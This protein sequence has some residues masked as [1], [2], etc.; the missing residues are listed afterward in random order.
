MINLDAVSGEIRYAGGSQQRVIQIYLKGDVDAE[1]GN[2]NLSDLD[3]ISAFKLELK[4]EGGWYEFFSIDGSP[5]KGFFT[6]LKYQVGEDEEDDMGVC[7]GTSSECSDFDK[8]EFSA[9]A[10]NNLVEGAIDF[11][12]HVISRSDFLQFDRVSLSTTID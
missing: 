1:T 2:V 9:T 5:S 3:H 4:D 8:L 7:L 10:F 11:A 6:N 12:E